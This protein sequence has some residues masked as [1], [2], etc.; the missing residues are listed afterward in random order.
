MNAK[1]RQ[2]HGKQP[3][4]AGTYFPGPLSAEQVYQ[5]YAAR[6]Y[7]TARRMLRSDLDAE[8]VTQDVLLQVVRK[9]PGFRG[10]SAFPTWLH[11]V[12]VNA[13]LLHRRRTGRLAR[14]VTRPLDDIRGETLRRAAGPRWLRGPVNQLLERETTVLVE[15]AIASLP[16]GYRQ[17]LVGADVEELPNR[18]VAEQLRLTLPAF[19]SRLHRARLML[20]DALAPHLGEPYPARAGA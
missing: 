14:T 20:R 2:R 19:K 17:A 7:R 15:R 16:D 13:A 9:L 1:V 10:E 12:T 8:D 3:R 6:V 18:V 11:R 5:D 4:P